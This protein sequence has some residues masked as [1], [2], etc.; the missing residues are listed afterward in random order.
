MEASLCVGDRFCGDL[1]VALNLWGRNVQGLVV[2]E[3]RVRFRATYRMQGQV[4]RFCPFCGQQIPGAWL[5][6]PQR[7]RRGHPGRAGKESS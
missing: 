5:L 1:E 2:F 3:G 6:E 7:V 4:L